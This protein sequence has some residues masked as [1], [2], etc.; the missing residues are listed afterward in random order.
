MA[1]AIAGKMRQMAA[2]ADLGEGSVGL[3]VTSPPCLNNYHYGRDTRPHLYWLGFCSS[4]R[5]LKHLE[6]LNFGA[7][8]QNAR[9]EERSD[10]DPSIADGAI[11][12]TLE[13]VR[14]QNPEKGVY[15][16]G[17]AND[18]A[19]Y[20]NDC[21]RFLDG[22]RRHRQLGSAGG[23]NPDRPF[24]RRHCGEAGLRRCGHSRSA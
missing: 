12:G 16:G 17:W 9:G 19:C 24:P 23:V 7:Y 6:V 11:S 15:G 20:F 18:A 10:L 5:D 2:D 1:A 14:R 21:A 22:A 13:A 4:P 8:R 3:P